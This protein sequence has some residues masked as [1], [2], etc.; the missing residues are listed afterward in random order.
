MSGTSLDGLD[1]A[2][3]VFKKTE[4]GWTYQ[5]EKA[6]TLRYSKSWVTNLSTAHTLRSEDLL[7][8]D[9]DY[10]RFLGKS[11]TDFTTQHNLK[12]DFIASHG[13]TIFHQPSRGFTYQLGNGNAMYAVV[14]EFP[15]YMIS[16]AWMFCLGGEGAPL[17][18]QEINFFFRNMMYA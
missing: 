3:C 5:I 4:K 7:A 13:H 17:F 14:Q 8:L 11:V 6:T 9:A 10:G 2:F 15:L 18:L 16:E 12:P 1:V